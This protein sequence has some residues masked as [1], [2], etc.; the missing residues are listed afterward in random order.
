MVIDLISDSSDDE[1]A[2][3]AP[4]P[5][6]APRRSGGSVWRTADEIEDLSDHSEDERLLRGADR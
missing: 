3:A 1:A 6:P 4:S 2:A 5:L